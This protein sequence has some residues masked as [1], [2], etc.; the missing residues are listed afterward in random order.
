[1][2]LETEVR[3][4]NTPAITAYGKGAAKDNEKFFFRD[5]NLAVLEA[6]IRRF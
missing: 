1:M 5:Y 6:C 2:K 3:S 4:K